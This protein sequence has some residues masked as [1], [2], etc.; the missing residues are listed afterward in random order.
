MNFREPDDFDKLGG[1]DDE[2]II[3]EPIDDSTKKTTIQEPTESVKEPEKFVENPFAK[4]TDDDLIEVVGNKII[5]DLLKKKGISDSAK[6]LYEN[7]KG[8]IEEKNFYDLPYEDQLNI[9]SQQ[10]EENDEFT[11]E[12]LFYVKQAREQGITLTDLIKFYQ[13]QSLEEYNKQQQP[14]YLVS[15][16]SDEELYAL[17]MKARLGDSITDE[18]II[19]QLQKELEIPEIFKKKVDKLRAEYI[20]LEEAERNAVD[21]SIKDKQATAFK[22]FGETITEV[23]H[24]IEDIGGV[25]LED[26]DKNDILKFMLEQDV[27]GTTQFQKQMNDPD[28][29]FLA[30]WAILK[31]Q[32][33]FDVLKEHYEGLLKNS[34][35]TQPVKTDKGTQTTVVR[36]TP[37]SAKRHMDITDLHKFDD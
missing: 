8:E 5:D 7:E 19:V 9:L 13:N 12:E 24:S 36:Q 4:D 23:V 6:V 21:Q 37:A 32:D 16:Y 35:K 34:K 17:D 11:E 25:A 33:T 20:E 14:K 30:A 27:N 2:E 15:D 1:F 10:E 22:E 3:N 29:I 18:E 31:A 28:N 26:T